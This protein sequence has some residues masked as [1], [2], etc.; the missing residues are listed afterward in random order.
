ML[1]FPLKLKF[2][3]LDSV[4]SDSVVVTGACSMNAVSWLDPKVT[5]QQKAV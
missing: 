2:D 4:T 3:D 5:E 1:P